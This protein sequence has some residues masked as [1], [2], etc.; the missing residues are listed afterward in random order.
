MLIGSNSE[1]SARTKATAVP[2]LNRPER[3]NAVNE[4]LYLEVRAALEAVTAISSSLSR[5][6]GILI[7]RRST[8]ART[9][10]ATALHPERGVSRKST[11]NSSPPKRA[12]MSR[13][14]TLRAG[15]HHRGGSPRIYAGGQVQGPVLGAVGDH[16]ASGSLVEQRSQH[17]TYSTARA[18]QQNSGTAECKLLIAGEIPHQADTVGIVPP[19]T[20]A[21]HHEGIDGPGITRPFAEGIG[22]AECAF[23]E[24]HRDVQ[25]TSAAGKELVDVGLEFLEV[26]EQAFIADVLPGLAGEG[27]VDL[28]GF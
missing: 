26:A 14:R 2:R 16:Q 21:R 25:P 17:A 18:K 9:C 15:P 28:W 11:A 1:G 8:P 7:I 5:S 13:P 27:V 10:S 4:E 23:L 24:R 12:T 3:M 20:V 19:N 22:V 6:S